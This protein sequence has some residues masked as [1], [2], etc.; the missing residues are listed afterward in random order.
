MAAAFFILSLKGL[1][2]EE[3]SLMG[4]AH[5]LHN[6]PAPRTWPMLT[7][8]AAFCSTGFGIMGMLVTVAA[9]F[10]SDYV[11]GDAYWLIPA[12]IVPCAL[13]GVWYANSVV[14]DRLPELVGLFNSFGGLAAAL[15]GIA[16]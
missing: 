11:Q 16:G 7:R 10:A 14:T 5:T 3:T 9:A 4:C 13:F 8:L 12:C 2:T 6:C 1:G 15:E